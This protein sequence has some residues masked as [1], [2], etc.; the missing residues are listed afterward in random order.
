MSGKN[1]Q[2]VY[3]HRHRLFYIHK[4]RHLT[5]IKS[6]LIVRKRGEDTHLYAKTT[7]R[8]MPQQ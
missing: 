7:H 1:D 5:V 8:R 4:I 3:L 6:S 2:V